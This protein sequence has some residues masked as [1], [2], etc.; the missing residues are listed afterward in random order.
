MA[1]DTLYHCATQ[2]CC[3]PTGFLEY[4]SCHPYHYKRLKANSKQANR[5]ATYGLML[6]GVLFSLTYKNDLTAGHLVYLKPYPAAWLFFVIFI[7][8]TITQISVIYFFTR[9]K[10]GKR[11]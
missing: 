11:R 1:S 3:K 4:I 7:Y 5:S 8:K 9:N 6:I 2:T 10:I